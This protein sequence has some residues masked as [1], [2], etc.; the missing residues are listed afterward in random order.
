MGQDTALYFGRIAG[1]AR[2]GK[3]SAEKLEAL[4]RVIW[5]KLDFLLTVR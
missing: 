2:L 5:G 4:L 1:R 3:N